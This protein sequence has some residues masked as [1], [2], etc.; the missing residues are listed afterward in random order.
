LSSFSCV[1]LTEPRLEKVIIPRNNAADGCL[2]ARSRRMTNASTSQR[3]LNRQFD[4]TIGEQ[5]NETGTSSTP[6]QLSTIDKGSP[7][8]HSREMHA[9]HTCALLSIHPARKLEASETTEEWRSAGPSRAADGSSSHVNG[10]KSLG[11]PC[12][13][14][15][16]LPR[17]QSM[18]LLLA[19]SY[20]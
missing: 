20:S 8:P 11:F 12:V 16:D 15:L 18:V 13:L 3:R 6:I 2:W 7:Q 10:Y 14:G 5:K 4:T 17:S 1:V 9:Q 19:C